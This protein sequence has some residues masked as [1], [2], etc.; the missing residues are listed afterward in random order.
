VLPA[1]H[2]GGGTLSPIAL[3]VRR[4]LVPSGR[5]AK[6]GTL[7]R[8][9]RYL[10]SFHAPGLGRLTLAWYKPAAR[11]RR[12]TLLASVTA[13]FAHASTRT[14]A[15]TLSAKG[16]RLL[17]HASRM[18]VSARGSFVANASSPV[19]TTATFTLHR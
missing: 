14:I 10:A 19:S 6:I 16:K 2:S 7:V 1:S 18:G 15:I 11:H 13:I 9:G 8:R 4:A 12:P 17:K 3:A 5:G